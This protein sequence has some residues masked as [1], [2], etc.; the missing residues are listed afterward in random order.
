MSV[1]R[2]VFVITGRVLGAMTPGDHT[3]SGGK[4]EE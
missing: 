3:G 1:A 2:F 4:S